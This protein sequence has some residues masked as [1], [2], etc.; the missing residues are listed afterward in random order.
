MARDQV[1]QITGLSNRRRDVFSSARRPRQDQPQAEQAPSPGV[2]EA[3]V[4]LDLS[5]K[6]Q[7]GARVYTRLVAVPQTGQLRIQVLDAE[8]DKVVAEMDAADLGRGGKLDG[9]GTAPTSD[10]SVSN[11]GG[12]HD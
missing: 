8:T 12:D 1:P 5:S 10:Q 7:N 4:T 3:A 2:E 11:V 9:Y 6:K